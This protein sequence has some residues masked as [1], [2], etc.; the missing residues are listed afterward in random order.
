[1]QNNIIKKIVIPVATAVLGALLT[2]LIVSL[3]VIGPLNK[4]IASA[5]DEKAVLANNLSVTTED[6]EKSKSNL[7]TLQSDYNAVKAKYDELM[8]DATAK[9]QE[10]DK[11]NDEV[12]KAKDDLKSQTGALEKAKRGVTTLD[13]LD[14]LFVKYDNQSTELAGILTQYYTDLANGNQGTSDELEL[15]FNAKSLEVEA[16]YKSIKELLDKFRDGNY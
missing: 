12:K 13:K 15:K 2:I 9:Q 6:F 3:A 11:I 4:Q 1:M 10:I 14:E 8:S 16:T 7:T 5:N